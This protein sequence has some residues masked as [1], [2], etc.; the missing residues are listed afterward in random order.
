MCSLHLMLLG[1]SSHDFGLQEAIKHFIIRGSNRGILSFLCL[2]KFLILKYF[3]ISFSF[4]FIA[5][6]R[7]DNVI[8]NS[9]MGSQ[10][11]PR[12]NAMIIPSLLSGNNWQFQQGKHY[13]NRQL[14]GTNAKQK[15]DQPHWKER[16]K[17]NF[18][19]EESRGTGE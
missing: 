13:Q 7:R 17:I 10:K 6:R 12:R 8:T 16:I 4:Y 2:F 9:L 15:Y 11:A 19:D 5:A 3:K 1:H 14:R 18:D